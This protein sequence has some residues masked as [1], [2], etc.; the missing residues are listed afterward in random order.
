M[1]QIRVILTD[2]VLN[3]VEY[4]GITNRRCRPWA[5]CNLVCRIR[6]EDDQYADVAP[7]GLPDAEIKEPAST[8]AIE[9]FAKLRAAF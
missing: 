8:S 7:S 5:K 4:R 1:H 6:S 2:T 9:Q 3:M